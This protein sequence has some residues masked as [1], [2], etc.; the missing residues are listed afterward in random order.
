[1]VL[2]GGRRRLTDLAA[3]CDIDLSNATGGKGRCGVEPT[4]FLYKGLCER[5]GSFEILQLVGVLQ[6][7]DD[8]LRTGVG[9]A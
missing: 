8:A 3:K 4:E 1:M 7:G 9:Y 2:N 5:W 6:K